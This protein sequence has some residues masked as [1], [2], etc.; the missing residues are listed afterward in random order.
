MDSLKLILCSI[1]DERPRTELGRRKRAAWGA[2]K[3]IEDVVKKI[4]NT[5]HRA[6]LFN[7][8]FLS[9]LTYASETWALR[10]QDEKAVSVIESSIG[11]V[12][13][14][15]TCPTQVR[16]VIRSSTLRQQSKTRD[17]ALY[18][19][20]YKIRWAGHVISDWAPWNVK[21]TTRRPP[22]RWLDF[23]MKSFKERYDTLRVS[24]TGRT[25]WTTLA[26]ERDKWKNC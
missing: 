14:G 7:T 19:K 26:R 23:F 10:K 16:A 4:K 9:A 17:A 20:L 15:V 2:Y 12:M 3:S 13:V 5:R 22:T 18:A 1:S 21:C 8:T 11:R 24:R 6:H 25:H